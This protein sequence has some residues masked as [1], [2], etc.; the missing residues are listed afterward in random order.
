MLLAETV[1]DMGVEVVL[2]NM[3]VVENSP[4]PLVGDEVDSDAFETILN[5]VELETSCCVMIMLL[6]DVEVG[7]NIVDDVVCSVKIALLVVVISVLSIW[8]EV[9]ERK[10]SQSAPV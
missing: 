8:D 4:V 3:D 1:V 7:N 5:V 2:L 6:L 9:D 10:N